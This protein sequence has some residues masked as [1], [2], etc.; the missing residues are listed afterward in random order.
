MLA[1]IWNQDCWRKTEE[2]SISPVFVGKTRD[3]SAARCCKTH[4]FVEETERTQDLKGGQ[5]KAI[6]IHIPLEINRSTV[7]ETSW[8]KYSSDKAKPRRLKERPT[9]SKTSNRQFRGWDSPTICSEVLLSEGSVGFQC[10]CPDWSLSLS[11]IQVTMKAF[12]QI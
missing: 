7:K 10:H 1:L 5:G 8:M 6:H 3:T 2:R 12:P 9:K 4:V 11:L